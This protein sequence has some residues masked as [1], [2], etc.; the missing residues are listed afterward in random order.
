[1]N[2]LGLGVEKLSLDIWAPACDVT[3]ELE[4]PSLSETQTD[5]D[6]GAGWDLSG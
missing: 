1:M 4:G 3:W 6:L 2:R 5:L